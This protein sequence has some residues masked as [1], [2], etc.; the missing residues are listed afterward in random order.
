M[1]KSDLKNGM[2]VELENG[3]KLIVIDDKLFGENLYIPLSAYRNDLTYKS[4]QD[5]CIL[6]VYEGEPSPFGT[7]LK[8][9]SGELIW[10]RKE[11][12]DWNKVPFGAKVRCYLKGENA[13]EGLFVSYKESLVYPYLVYVEE[14]GVNYYKS[15]ELLEEPKE[16]VTLEELENKY[17]DFE[18]V[19]CGECSCCKY[20]ESNVCE[21][22]WIL[23]NYNV[24]RK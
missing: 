22:A 17:D 15:C 12:T 19:E 24:T 11:E 6:K 4:F 1:K 8:D 16:E 2:V 13:R 10:E 3:V 18:D 23:D 7:L 14:Y 20:K 9:F 21:F 5:Y